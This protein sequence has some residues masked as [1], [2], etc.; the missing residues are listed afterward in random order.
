MEKSGEGGGHPD[1]VGADPPPIRQYGRRRPDFH[2]GTTT[3]CSAGRSRGP[4]SARIN[5]QDFCQAARIVRAEG[6]RITYRRDGSFEI[7]PS[8]AGDT[9]PAG[10]PQVQA[11]S[12]LPAR[13]PPTKYFLLRRDTGGWVHGRAPATSGE[14]LCSADTTSSQAPRLNGSGF[15]SRV[16]HGSPT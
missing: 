4:S 10:T 3:P 7:L 2:N 8:L 12:S 14:S 15:W 16:Y 9:R 13:Q 6:V 1:G 11:A 5:W